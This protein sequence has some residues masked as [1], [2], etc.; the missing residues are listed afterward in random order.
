MKIMHNKKLVPTLS[1]FIFLIFQDISLA[2]KCESLGLNHNL[3]NLSH[4]FPQ[5]RFVGLFQPEKKNI[6]YFGLF[7]TSLSKATRKEL[8]NKV[9]T[10]FTN[11]KNEFQFPPQTTKEN[12]LLFKVINTTCPFM[13]SSGADANTEEGNNMLEAL[14]DKCEISLADS[15]TQT[16]NVT[17]NSSQNLCVCIIKHHNTSFF[18]SYIFDKEISASCSK[19]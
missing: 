12:V 19:G 16:N 18:L 17:N 4:G 11:N 10:L 15:S 2:E 8:A 7:E 14:T 5:Y 3:S 9:M 6:W 1:F 13:E